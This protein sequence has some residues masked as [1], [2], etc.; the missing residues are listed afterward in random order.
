MWHPANHVIIV[1]RSGIVNC[2]SR[3]TG[4]QS[5][6]SLEQQQDT[7]LAA[8][9]LRSRGIKASCGVLFHAVRLL[10]IVIMPEA[11]KY[12]AEWLL[13]MWAIFIHCSYMQWNILLVCCSP[14]RLQFHLFPATFHFVLKDSTVSKN[15]NPSSFSPPSQ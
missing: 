9:S 8:K 13:W 1:L 5:V 15:K 10:I 12:T 6:T 11:A 4:M 2:A 3:V 7:S 14:E